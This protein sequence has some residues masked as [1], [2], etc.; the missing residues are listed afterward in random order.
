[1]F[2][3]KRESN[4]EFRFVGGP[5]D[6]YE[7]TMPFRPSPILAFPVDRNLLAALHGNERPE[8][9]QVTS[10]A[11]YEGLEVG[12]RSWRFRFL[13]SIAPE[14]AGRGKGDRHL[15]RRASSRDDLGTAQ[16]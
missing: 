15:F 11:F 9:S 14:E 7:Q 8:E 4:H 10:V 3:K 2:W 5:L 6:G 16:E 12:T 1:M 13:K